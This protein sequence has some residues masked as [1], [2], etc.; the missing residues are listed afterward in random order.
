MGRIPRSRKA[1][2]IFLVLLSSLSLLKFSGLFSQTPPVTTIAVGNEPRGLAINPATSKAIVTNHNTNT[3]TVANLSNNSTAT[4]AVGQHPYGVAINASTN[5]AYIANEKSDTVSVLNLSNNSVSATIPVGANPREIAV[6]PGTN[7]AVVANTKSDTVSILNLSNNTVSQHLS[8]GVDPEGVV[9][10][11]VNNRAYVTNFGSDTVSVI[12]LGNKTVTA[13]LAVGS[14]PSGVA[15]HPTS[16]RIVVAN[17]LSDT[18]SILD[19]STNL[20]IATVSVGAGPTGA[21]IHTALNRAYITNTFSDSISVIDLSNNSVIATYPAGRNPEGIA[22]VP[23]TNQLVIANDKAD[24]VLVIDLANPPTGT[25]VPVGRD[26][27]GVA[28]D[29]D[30]NVAV[31]ANTKSN[32]LSVVDLSNGTLLA[33]LP[34]GK[35]PKDVAIHPASKR[36]VSADSKANTASVYDLP[37]R[38]LLA[39]VPVGRRPRAVAIDPV[40]NIAAVANERDGTLSLIDLSSNAV[41][42]TIA[43]GS[44]PT[45]IDIQPSG[46]LAVVANKKTDAVTIVDLVNRVTV[47]TVAVGKD[48][49]SIAVNS[50]TNVA[51][52][53]N[54]KSNTLSIIN[55]STHTVTATIAVQSTPT[56]AAI[57]TVTNIAAVVSHETKNVQTVNLATNT[58]LTPT[59]PAGWEPE[60]VTINPDTNMAIVTNED[61]GAV[62]IIQL[63]NPVPIL[64]SLS[65]TTAGAGGPGF[66]LTL[67]GSKFLK[68]S[69]VK[70]GTQ[71]LAAQF[72]SSGQITT[73]VPASAIAQAGSVQVSVINPAPGGGTSGGLTF[74]VNTSSNPVPL[75]SSLSPGSATAGAAGFTLTI[76]GSNF[77]NASSAS[78]N[79]QAVATTYVSSIRLTASV[80][81][82]AIATAGSFPVTVTNPAPGGGTSSA[83]TFTVNNPAPTTTSIAPSSVLAGSAAT[84]LTV[85]GTNFVGSST[86]RFNGTSVTTTY[87]SATQLT[88][89][90]PA[91]Q[92]PLAGTFSVTVVNPAPGGGTSNVQTFTVNNPVPTTA[93]IAPTS[94]VAGSAGFTL[95]LNG[96]GFVGASSVALNG[97]PLT[98]T[99]VSATQVTAVVPASAVATAG[100][101]PVTVTNPAPGGGLSNSQTLTVNNPTPATT[102][103]SPSAVSAGS[104]ATS[105]TI[106]G[107]QFVTS[108]TISFNGI[109]LTT[110]YGSATQLTA[111][112]P[113][114]LLS[115][116][117]TFPVTVINPG[118]GGGT[119]NPQTFTVN[120]PVPAT[121][122]ISPASA[123]AGAGPTPFTVD[124]THFVATSSISFNG[125]ALATT[126]VSA[127]RL[128]ATIPS[129][130]LSSAGTFPVTVVSPAPGGGTSNAQT[131]TVN[132]PIP[133]VGTVS[134]ASAVAGSAGFALTV[135]GTNFAATASV[136]FNGTA[137]TTTY[138]NSSQLTASVPASAVAIAG[139]FPVIVTNPAPGGG[140][141]NTA[142]FIV[143]NPVPTIGALS[144]NSIQA[145]STAFVL[146]LTGTN[147]VATSTASFAGTPLATAFVNAAQLTAAVPSSLIASA[148][149]YNVTVSNPA[150]GGGAS[151]SL[152]FTV[153]N[154]APS[155][156]VISPTLVVTGSG[157]FT[158]TVN[159]SNFVSTSS[160]S[161]DGQPLTTTFVGPTVLTATVPS[162]AAAVSHTALITIGNPAPGGGTSNAANLIVNLSPVAGA[163]SGRSAT[164]GKAIA[165]DGRRSLDPDGDRITFA[166]SILS[167]PAGSAASLVNP[168]G[169]QPSLTP[170]LAGSYQIQLIV[171]DGK[172]DSAPAAVT[173]TA[174]ATNAPAN[175]D[176]GFDQTAVVGQPVT[177]EGRKS[178]DPD[179]DRIT[180]LWSLLSGPAGSAATLTGATSVLSSFTPDLAG[181][182][183]V[184]LIV[185]DGTADSAPAEV[186]VVAASPNAPPMARAGKDRNGLTGSPVHLDG[187]ASRDPNGDPLT[188]LWSVVSAP[189]GSTAALSGGTTATPIFTPDLSGEYLVRLV[190]TDGVSASLPDTALIVA[191]SPNPAPNAVA[192]ADQTVYQTDTVTLDGTGSF[193][194][195]TDPVV[196]RWSIVSAPAGSQAV[197]SSATAVHPSFVADAAGSYLFRLVV[198]DGVSDSFADMAV[199]TAAP[200]V[201]L[202]VT[203][204]NPSITQGQ[205]QPFAASASFANNTTKD[206]TTF[207]TWTSSDTTIATINAAGVVTSLKGGTTLIRAAY[208]SIISPAQTLTVISL[209]PT[210]TGFAPLSGVIGTAVTITGTNFDTRTP[211]NNKIT[212][213]GTPAILTSVTATAIT[214]TAPLGA[215][216]GPI[217]ITTPG[218]SAVSAAPFTVL[219]KEDFSL[220]AAPGAVSVV[221][222]RTTTYQ[223]TI[224]S[225]GQNLLTHL[226]GLSASGLPAGATATFTPTTASIAQVPTMTLTTTASTPAG[227]FPI[228]ISGLASLEGRN[229]VRTATVQ[230]SVLASGGTTLAGRILASKDDAP[231]PGAKLKL[232][233]QV[234]VTD[235]S[236]NFFF[237]AP[238]I[239]EQV[240]L[241]DGPT[242]NYP[243]DLAIPATIASGA[244]NVLPYPIYLH[245]ISQNFF[246]IPP[247]QETVVQPPEVPDFT[248]LIPPGG[249]IMGWDGQPNT[250][251]SITPVPLDR[252]AIR[253]LPPQVDTRTLYMFSFGKPGGGYPNQPIPIIYPND[254]GAFP[255]ERVDLW[256]YDESPTPDPNSQQWKIYGQGTV[257]PDGKRIVPDP[258]VGMPKFCCGGSFASRNAAGRDSTNDGGPSSG[259]SDG[260]TEEADPVDLSTGQFIVRKTDLVLPG[261]MPIQITR[262]LRSGATSVGPFGK[263]GG[264][265]F[266]LFAVQF[267]TNAYVYYMP[268]GQRY[269]FSGQADGT[270]VNTNYPFLRGIV[271]TPLLKNQ[272]QVRLRDGTI[273]IFDNLGYLLE[274]RDRNN[275]RI[276]IK[277]DEIN[278]ITDLIGPGGRAFHFT[279]RFVTDDGDLSTNSVITSITDP[280]GRK[281]TY[282]YTGTLLTKVTDP[283]DGVTQYAYGPLGDVVSITDPKGI[284]YLVNEYD[285]DRRVIKQTLADG[286]FYTFKYTLA[287]SAITQ[288]E[289]TDPNGNTTAY[290]FNSRKYVARI[291]DANGQMTRFERDFA[292]NQLTA[293]IDPLNR[294]TSFTYDLNGNT[295]SVVDPAGNFTLMEYEPT[296]NKL[297][298]L[299]DALNNVN[300]FAYDPS[301]NL[302][303]ATDPLGNSTNITYSNA[304]Q[305]V[306]VTDALQNTTSL[307]YDN[308][309]DLVAT[310][311]PLGNKTQRGYDFVSRLM[312]LTEA[313]GKST[314]FSYNVLNQVT[315]ITDAISGLTQFTH[316]PNGNLLTVTDAKGQTTTYNYDN[317]DRLATRT[318]PLNRS[319][320]YMYD[321]NGNLKT[322][323]DRKGQTT[324][325]AYDSLNRRIKSTFADGSSV[326][327]DHNGTRRLVKVTDS[328]SGV[329][330]FSY[331]FLLD[332]LT[333]ETTA[334]GIVQYAYDALGRRT[335]MTVSG[336]EP[337]LYSYDANSRPTQFAQGAQIVGLGYDAMGRRTG[338]TYPNGTS[339]AY[340]HD[341]ASRLTEILHQSPSGV[342][343]DL[344]YSY[345]PVGNR[346]RKTHASGAATLLPSAVQAEYDIANEQ[347]Q[348][349]SSVPNL[350]YDANGNLISRIDG[351]GTTAYTWDARNR[352]VGISAPNL[353]ASFVYDPLGKRISKTING[354][355]TD[356]TY[357]GQDIVA[358]ISGGAVE[359]NYLRALRVD[360][361][362]I[363]SGSGEEYYHSD[364][365]GSTLAITDHSAA[366]QATYQYEPFGKTNSDGTSENRFQYAG[367]E[368]DG[369]GVY[370]YR[371]RYYSPALQRFISR[372]PIGFNGGST[373]LYSYVL[374]SPTNLR[375]PSGKNPACLIG[376]LLGTIGYNGYVIYESLAGRKAEYYAGWEGLARILAGNA[377]AYGAG[378]I[379][380]SVVGA[381]ADAFAPLT[382]PPGEPLPP[383][384]SD[385][386]EYRYPEGRGTSSPRWFDESGGEWRYHDIDPWHST[387]HWDYNPWTEWN[388]PWQNIFP[389]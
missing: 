334:Q 308:F 14:G 352:L 148:G 38:T 295:T 329:I 125:A 162:S 214:T 326:T 47:A 257:T 252:I 191:A 107:S 242:S 73:N 136:S 299:T 197:L 227:S 319:Q 67:N 189:A 249:V 293:V 289:V 297:V 209:P 81:A 170:D 203:P 201:S 50:T 384:W 52:V 298:K 169:V 128:T 91:S 278:R 98:T 32:D 26:P 245:E 85:N 54:E 349:S 49:V 100:V 39:T 246:S 188:Y 22:V 160:I 88:A 310:T 359:A 288:T 21:A 30:S 84:S 144:Q 69:Q 175:A 198:S 194:P 211:S 42:A 277:R 101:L 181:T 219:A 8:V 233:G 286:G 141:S 172:A 180:Y 317:M 124:G 200:I 361:P 56:G 314:G 123:L 199:V 187:G 156:G 48:P 303:Q 261:L 57:N 381:I 114:D 388:S 267:G 12:D 231:I 348:F 182:Y 143:N 266:D 71:T 126:Y 11:T 134:P 120:N 34:A 291:V 183:V 221:Q 350:T 204:T 263:G 53:A 23:S 99:Y 260:K 103:I 2:L 220:S 102:S 61:P 330:E 226:I 161:V 121:T 29:R 58:V 239:G 320:R 137:L 276:V 376:G 24:T 328:T 63:S 110:A 357:D 82:S 302:I 353:S 173:V 296:F 150:P 270:F 92:L 15:I 4:V 235:A 76:D 325:F 281:V 382:P 294:K 205:T 89:T 115:S 174:T 342:I 218:G 283:A 321:P 234:A 324:T 202:A 208:G 77:I 309:G 347:I 196:Y 374:N 139:S 243:A 300:R 244:A 75:I 78:F 140:A 358:E 206:V 271:L 275:N 367:R 232:A 152:S 369:T 3:V 165:L 345:D 171:N 254:L 217:G 225:A 259:P 154:P 179:D 323:A 343:E 375:D 74:T 113:A 340:S 389:P 387:P 111:T 247:G 228:T 131:F 193:D 304:G 287:G 147:F 66:T 264:F 327:Y 164:V 192:G 51:A 238:P 129:N 362:F 262:T 371:A 10:N 96:A 16:Q 44:H 41:T 364:A 135:N 237:P 338:L 241:L 255:G 360:E 106:N 272:V 95:T 258:G 190:V 105:L 155:I 104:A 307:E 64:S 280:I 373:N 145:E 40:L 378:C 292:T 109:S 146:T 116:A 386:W 60:Q 250:K 9:I 45:D 94:V 368:N 117:G 207:V 184:R 118:P 313:N 210:I 316:D 284:T 72:V 86:V 168:T 229:V 236:G 80:P 273:Q 265:S 68:S 70:F 19:G 178:G 1:I 354:V 274:V 269:I 366:V 230:L 365:L 59:L 212:F 20:L 33:T 311:D 97:Q 305:P 132:N 163:G 279:Y 337:V 222:G 166:W 216:T 5:K 253:P 385:T 195:N 62:A 351:N 370:Y 87:V 13:T 248:M 306:T 7:T 133:S 341:A 37:T 27:N 108:S 346:T 356:Y 290:R 83:Q 138:V 336:G 186:R 167:A 344:L 335:S 127:T 312:S 322:F 315:Q 112:I 31:T 355:R 377:T 35:A 93:S 213:N 157:L 28:L 380:G 331:D 65:P 177:L 176:A 17:R 36:L 142:V 301:G 149:I 55:L 383:R 122:S 6:N 379:V 130:L 18:V 215:A 153:T 90:I 224:T 251:V 151:N 332:R 43:A 240:L 318:D 372:D 363:R 333:Q 268:D 339:A 185:N 282:D 159:G 46:H 119:A 158:L 79:G 25:I 256:Y 285:S 223:I